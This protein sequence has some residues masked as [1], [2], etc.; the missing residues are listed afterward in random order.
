MGTETIAVRVRAFARLRELLDASEFEIRLPIG[1]TLVDLWE[2]LRARNRAI[3]ALASSTRLARNGRVAPLLNVR[4]ED[5][6]EVALLPPVG[7]G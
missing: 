2:A 5:G 1:A 7:G 6:D 3:D 4:L